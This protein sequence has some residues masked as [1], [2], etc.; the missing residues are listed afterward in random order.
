MI[1]LD[2][3]S[4]DTVFWNLKYVLNIQYSDN[5]LSINTNGVLMKLHWNCDIPY[6]NDV[7][8]NENSITNIDSMKDKTKKICVMMDLKEE[9]ALL[10]HTTNKIVKFKQFTNGL[11]DMDLN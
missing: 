3:D 8:Y 10:V 1:L 9:L 5:Q 11:Y 2:S 4:T 6:N 7:W